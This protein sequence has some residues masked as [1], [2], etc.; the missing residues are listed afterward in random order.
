[1]GQILAWL[2]DHVLPGVLIAVVV[3]VLHVAQN[4]FLAGLTSSQTQE[5][6]AAAQRITDEQTKV[7]KPSRAT[8]GKFTK[9]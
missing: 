2:A 3:W 5:L 4:K 9:S 6:K 1:M 8:N 7:L